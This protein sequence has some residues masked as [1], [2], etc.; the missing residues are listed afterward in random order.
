MNFSVELQ[1]VRFGIVKTNSVIQTLHHHSS[2][3]TQ[4]GQNKMYQ[5]VGGSDCSIKLGKYIILIYSFWPKWRKLVWEKIVF[6]V[7]HQPVCVLCGLY[8]QKR[9]RDIQL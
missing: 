7:C 2:Y 9:D 5:I 8:Q 3:Y 4:L 1:A 6:E